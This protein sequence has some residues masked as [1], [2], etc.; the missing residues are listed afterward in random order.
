M[1]GEGEEGR[2][3]KAKFNAVSYFIVASELNIN[4]DL[5][6]TTDLCDIFS[7]IS[8]ETRKMT[9]KGFSSLYK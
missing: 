8:V 7:V 2:E 1:N 6:H 5:F 3:R 9:F 4:S